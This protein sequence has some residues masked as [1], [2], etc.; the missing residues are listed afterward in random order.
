[1]EEIISRLKTKIDALLSTGKQIVIFVRAYS[2][3]SARADALVQA[4]AQLGPGAGA[5]TIIS[6]KEV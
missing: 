4:R 2:S 6:C 5:V 1:M 3:S